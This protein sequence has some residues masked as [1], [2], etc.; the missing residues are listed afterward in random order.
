MNDICRHFK[1]AIR[2]K[3]SSVVR[4]RARVLCACV[5]ACTHARRTHTITCTCALARPR[6]QVVRRLRRSRTHLQH[7]RVM[8]RSRTHYNM[9]RSRTHYN[10]C[11]S[12]THY[13][14]CR[15][16]THYNMRRSRTHYNLQHS[17]HGARTH[18][19]NTHACARAQVVRLMRRYARKR[20]AAIGD[21]G[22]DVAMIQA[23]RAPACACACVRPSARLFCVCARQHDT[24]G[25][26]G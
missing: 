22:N 5:R 18:A 24:N 1:C 20:C 12:R 23:P 9:R 13:N 15:S 3:S 17:E 26:S 4:A 10:M 16:R 11:R 2:I 19:P 21:G 6:T 8:C 7:T 14:M 25:Q